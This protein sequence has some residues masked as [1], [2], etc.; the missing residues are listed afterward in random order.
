MLLSIHAGIKVN[1]FSKNGYW[2]K[3]HA[4]SLFCF[5][6]FRLVGGP[7]PFAGRVEVLHDGRWG[8]VCG[9]G[10]NQKAADVVCKLIGFE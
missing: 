2:N 9:D 7:T 1:Q 5:S 3:D 6:E 8:T 4:I 10:F